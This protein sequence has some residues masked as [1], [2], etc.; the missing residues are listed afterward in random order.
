MTL[1]EYIY[2]ERQETVS[3]KYYVI[4]SIEG[5]HLRI[6]SRL[7]VFLLSLLLLLYLLLLLLFCFVFFAFVFFL[8]V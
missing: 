4:V 5:H 6:I 1:S 2:F 8:A 3:L 7:R